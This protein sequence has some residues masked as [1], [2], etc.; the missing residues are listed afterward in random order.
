MDAPPPYLGEDCTTPGTRGQVVYRWAWAFVQ[1]TLF[2]WSPRPCHRWR[3]WLLSFFGAEIANTDQVVIFPTVRV[4]YP[5]RLELAD[6]SMVGP[7]VEIY[8]LGKVT[9][10]YGANVSQNCHLCSGTHDFNRWDMPLVTAPIVIGKNAWLAADV[11]VGPG[12]SIGE[13]AVVGAR[14]VVIKDQPAH[15][16]CAGNPCRPVKPRALPVSPE[17]HQS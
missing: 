12:V 3:A 4:T 15:M 13:L 11:F 17:S 9:L 6:R 16:V 5:D 2:R 10:Q 14:S 1:A 8:N 7:R